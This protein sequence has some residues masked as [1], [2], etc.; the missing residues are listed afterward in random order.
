MCLFAGIAVMPIPF[1]AEGEA[2]FALSDDGVVDYK[3]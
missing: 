1:A 3:E 2:S